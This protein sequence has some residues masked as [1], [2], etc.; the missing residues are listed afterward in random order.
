MRNLWFIFSLYWYFVTFFLPTLTDF[1]L[2]SLLWLTERI[3]PMTCLLSGK[4]HT[5]WSFFLS[6]VLVYR[7]VQYVDIH[8]RFDFFT[9]YVANS[10]SIIMRAYVYVSLYIKWLIWIIF[11]L[12]YSCLL[13]FIG[14]CVN[15]VLYYTYILDISICSF[16]KMSYNTNI[17]HCC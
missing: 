10:F 4:H 6:V 12:I 5:H 15:I 14:R 9:H 7:I 11:L 3:E 8:V 13:Y 16:G 1:V 17:V 2:L